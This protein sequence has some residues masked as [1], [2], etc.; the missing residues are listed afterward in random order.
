AD[1]NSDAFKLVEKA[2]S[3]VYPD[4]K[5]VPYI[6]TAASDCRFFSRNSDNCL[7]FLPFKISDEQMASIHGYDESVDVD[8]LAPAVD[9]YRYIM[10][11]L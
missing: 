3:A 4:V 9:F 1:Y 6:M 2:V 11:T 7:R 5:T 10:K 8:T